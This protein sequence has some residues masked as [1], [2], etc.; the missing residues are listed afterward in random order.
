MTSAGETDDLRAKVRQW[1]ER[2]AGVTNRYWPSAEEIELAVGPL[3]ELAAQ[4][5]RI[6]FARVRITPYPRNRIVSADP[7]LAK[8]LARAEE[9]LGVALRDAGEDD[10]TGQELAAIRHSIRIALAMGMAPSAPAGP[11]RKPSSWRRSPSLR[12]HAAEVHDILK[13]HMNDPL[14]GAGTD[15]NGVVC[16]FMVE[17]T[18][19]FWTGAGATPSTMAKALGGKAE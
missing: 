18:N 3:A 1:L 16:R 13:T 19:F 10:H 6:V 15:E 8:A 9:A 17:F 11:G 12:R 2:P 5:P 7:A 4:A 14:L